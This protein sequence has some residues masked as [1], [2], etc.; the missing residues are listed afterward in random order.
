M[1]TV[2]DVLQE[3]CEQ[4]GVTFKPVRK[5]HGDCK[6]IVYGNGGPGGICCAL[7]LL[8]LSRYFKG[9]MDNDQFGG[10]SFGDLVSALNDKPGLVQNGQLFWQPLV[11]RATGENQGRETGWPT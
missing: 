2:A 11:E 4:A 9:N 8:W 1:T 6:Q 7:S 10:D 3:C 5:S